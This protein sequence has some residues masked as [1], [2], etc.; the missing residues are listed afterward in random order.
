M[1]LLTTSEALE[2]LKLTNHRYLCYLNRRGLLPR[3]KFGHRTFRYEEQAIERLIEMVKN[4]GI[5]L[6]TKA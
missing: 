3:L 6:M 4:Q 1:T 5:N 2:K